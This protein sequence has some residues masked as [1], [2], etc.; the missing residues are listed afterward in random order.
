MRRST[1]STTWTGTASTTIRGSVTPSAWTGPSIR[2]SWLAFDDDR[3]A[4]GAVVGGA[5]LHARV[6][7]R[8]FARDD[9][10]AVVHVIGRLEESLDDPAAG[11]GV[12]QGGGP[13]LRR[14]EAAD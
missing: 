11:A 2:S 13:D 8:G 10:D 14:R 9:K 1:G 3:R 5:G 12:F 4:D 7:A 6:E